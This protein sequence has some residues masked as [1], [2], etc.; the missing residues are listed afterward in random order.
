MSRTRTY[1]EYRD[2]GTR[3]RN[4]VLTNPPDFDYYRS[5]CT[6]ETLSGD[7]YPLDITR[8]VLNGGI[9]HYSTCPKAFGSG[10]QNYTC[11]AIKARQQPFYGHV[12]L[13]GVPSDSAV[14]ATVLAKTNPS[15]P[16]VDLPVALLELKD[17]PQLF[18]TAGKPFL[19]KVAG[20]NLSYQFGIKPLAS[21][22]AKLIMFSD[23]LDKRVIELNRLAERGLY[24]RIDIGEFEGQQT[25]NAVVVQSLF[26]FRE[27]DVTRVTKSTVSGFVKWFP[28]S[29]NF[30][31]SDASIKSLARKAALGLTVDFSTAWNLIPWSWLVD[32][33]TSA[34]DFLMAN[35][36]IVPSTHGPVQVM[37]HTKTEHTFP[38]IGDISACYCTTESKYRMPTTPSPFTA[39]LPILSGKQMSILGSIGVLSGKSRISR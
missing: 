10:F 20:A 18:K 39:H 15:R 21:D 37:R 38:A 26:A 7:G 14:A 9:L 33:C 5:V 1:R 6:D 12:S 11:D 34:G 22:L 25:H 3:C 16:S 17:F 28:A 24:R 27:R 35:R 4:G 8:S 30:P 2:A 29:N 19:K 13:S 23:I 31:K 32:W 36:N